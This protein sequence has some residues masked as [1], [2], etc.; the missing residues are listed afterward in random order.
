MSLHSLFNEHFL[1]MTGKVNP[2][3]LARV[4]E[5]CDGLVLFSVFV[6]YYFPKHVLNSGI[7]S[8]R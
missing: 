1:A 4:Q 8:E 2:F 5:F 6:S 7:I 3:V